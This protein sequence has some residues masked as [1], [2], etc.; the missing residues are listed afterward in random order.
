MKNEKSLILFL[1][2]AACSCTDKEFI[3]TNPTVPNKY[4]SGMGMSVDCLKPTFGIIDEP[5]VIEGNFKGPVDSMRVYFNY[6]TNKSDPSTLISKRAVL[7]ATDGKTILGVVPKQMAGRNQVSVV[8]GKDSI[9]PNGMLFKYNQRKSVKTLCGD[10]GSSSYADGDFTAAR[11]KEV[12]NIACVKGTK[13]DNIIAVESWW[14][15]RVSLI[16]NDDN[17]VITLGQT[18]SYGTPIVDNTREKFYLLSHWSEDRTIK[19][20]SRSD[21]WAE[22]STGIVIQK[23]DM[24]GQIWSGAFTEKD[25]R[26]LYLMDTQAHF[27]QVDLD[28]M[29]YKMITLIGDLPNQD[30]DR[31]HIIY[32]KYHKCFFASFYKMSGIYKIHQASDGSWRIEKYAGFNGSGSATG[33]RLQDAQFIEPFGM[34]CTSDGELYV[35]N[36]GGSFIN[37]VVG[38][39]VEIVAGKPGNSGQVNSDTEPTDARFN[40]PEDIAV[41]SEDNFY[42]AGGWD[43]TVRKMSIE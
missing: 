31:S 5:F 14:N 34:A 20:Y 25:N 27:C 16:S 2:L 23:S 43:R 32:S 12:S 21:S 15:N 41:D 8:V 39:Q 13:G 42:I 33:H 6:C 7:V 30:E 35:I 17:K 40:S 22:K 1:C 37:K 19:S 9:A 29:T 3:E 4:D 24:P 28:N 10:F 38:D 18:G 11:F 26:Y 36:R